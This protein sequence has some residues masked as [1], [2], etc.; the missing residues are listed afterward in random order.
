MKISES[1]REAQTTFYVGCLLGLLPLLAH[2]LVAASVAIE[3]IK[4]ENAIAFENQNWLGHLIFLALAL[5][6]G[7]LLNVSKVERKWTTH[8]KVSF[9][10][11]LSVTIFLWLLFGLMAVSGVSQHWAA[12]LAVCTL[13]VAGTIFAYNVDMA[14]ATLS[15]DVGKGDGSNGA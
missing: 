12:W 8:L 2:L 9:Y 14:I 3:V 15:S 13:V 10:H 4:F 11:L 7:S 1:K 5:G 6:S